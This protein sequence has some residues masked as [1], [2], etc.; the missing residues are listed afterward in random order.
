MGINDPPII[1]YPEEE[2][3]VGKYTI[4]ISPIDVD[5]DLDPNMTLLCL[6]CGKHYKPYDQFIMNEMEGFGFAWQNFCSD[7]CVRRYNSI[8]GS[9]WRGLGEIKRRI[10]RFIMDP[11]EKLLYVEE[12]PYC[13][14]DLFV[15]TKNYLFCANLDCEMWSSNFERHVSKVDG[16]KQVT[17]VLK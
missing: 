6:W 1:P 17:L 7:R 15:M 9:I 10:R 16:K 14:E 12:C 4:G 3:Q 5:R 2:I 8:L 11:I 13:G